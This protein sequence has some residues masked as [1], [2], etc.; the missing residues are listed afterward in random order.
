MTVF[1]AGCVATGTWW[2]EEGAPITSMQAPDQAQVNNPVLL[3]VR[4]AIGSSSC[5][6][7]NKVAVTV[8]ESLKEVHVTAT[9]LAKK[10]NSSLACSG[11]SANPI[12][13]ASF[14]PTSTGTYRVIAENFQA[15]QVP[16]EPTPSATI[17]VLVTAP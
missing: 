11:D 1:L 13:T 12:A 5:N 15:I 14:T 4:V 17:D 7:V 3:S 16:F 9:K 6:K 8:D 2:E 10:S